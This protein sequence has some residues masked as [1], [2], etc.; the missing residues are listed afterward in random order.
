MPDIFPQALN[1]EGDLDGTGTPTVFSLQQRLDFPIVVV[2][3]SKRIINEL[4]RWEV[5]LSGQTGT[6]E[7]STQTEPSTELWAGSLTLSRPAATDILTTTT[8]GESQ[9][10]TNVIDRFQS[11]YVIPLTDSAVAS[12]SGPYKSDLTVGG[13]GVLIPQEYVWLNLHGVNTLG[14]TGTARVGVRIWYRQRTI[15][16]DEYLGLLASRMQLTTDT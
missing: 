8:T 13:L 15:K 12:R 6:A 4:L 3:T 11:L 9:G 10:N 2:D 16:T 7:F 14:G 1:W 5:D